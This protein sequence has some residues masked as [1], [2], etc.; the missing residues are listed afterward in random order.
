MPVPTLWLPEW[1]LPWTEASRRNYTPGSICMPRSV[2][3]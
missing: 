2:M 1:G 3:V